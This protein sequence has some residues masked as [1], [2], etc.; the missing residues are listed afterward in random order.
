[1]LRND[2]SE[3]AYEALPLNVDQL[4]ELRRL[5]LRPYLHEMQRL[6]QR[7]SELEQDMI[8]QQRFLAD[9]SDKVSEVITETLLESHE[10]LSQAIAPVLGSAIKTQV[11][12][13]REDI[14]DALYPV[15]GSTITRSL[16]EA[17]RS[18][19]EA[20]DKNIKKTF[21]FSGFTRRVK[22][23][24]AG[25][26]E[27]ELA[28]REALPFDIT[29]IFLIHTET[30]LLISH[31]SAAYA[32]DSDNDRDLVSGM[33]TA[34]R[35]FVRESFKEQSAGSQLNQIQYGGLTILIE[36]SRYVYI[37]VVYAGNAPVNF[38]ERIREV[39]GW[40]HGGYAKPLR[41]FGESGDSSKLVKIK[42]LLYTLIVKN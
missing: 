31:V 21:S 14:I 9:F 2:Q 8:S 32:P 27:A 26:S 1:M 18:L 41:A 23:R 11:V 16:T 15:I 7:V 30:G 25:V 42:D 10:A 35:D 13:A 3:Y 29:E 24:V 12:V 19:V 39:L 40:V 5:I 4:E 6:Q 28:I 36:Q 38:S 17:M 20:I 34:I 33:L 22:S 37:A